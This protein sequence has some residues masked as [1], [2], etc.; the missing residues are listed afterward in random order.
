MYEGE[1]EM[2]HVARFEKFSHKR[3]RQ[4]VELNDAARPVLAT[5]SRGWRNPTASTR[6]LPVSVGIF[7]TDFD[8]RVFQNHRAHRRPGGAQP[9]RLKNKLHHQGG[10]TPSEYIELK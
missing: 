5:N 3:L 10:Q 9:D 4:R 1:A 8:P 2:E 7:Q 6:F